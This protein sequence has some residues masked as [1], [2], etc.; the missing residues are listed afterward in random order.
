MDK[1]HDYLVLL[2]PNSDD[3]GDLSRPIVFDHDPPVIRRD[4]FSYGACL[5]GANRVSLEPL[6]DT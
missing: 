2:D 3:V 4:Q 5:D 6:N 1:P